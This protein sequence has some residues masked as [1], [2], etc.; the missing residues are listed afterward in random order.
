MIFSYKCNGTKCEL[1]CVASSTYN[2]FFNLSMIWHQ[3]YIPKVF[4]FQGW[5]IEFYDYNTFYISTHPDGHLVCYHFFP[6]FNSS[7]GTFMYKYMCKYLFLTFF[8]FFWLHL[9]VCGI[10]NFSSPTRDWTCAPYRELQ[11][12]NHWTTKED[13]LIFFIRL[14]TVLPLSFSSLSMASRSSLRMFKMVDLKSL[15]R[16]C[17]FCSSLQTPSLMQ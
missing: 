5:I 2:G 12:L 3:Y 7:A 13:P 15:L 10:L 8:F 6:N 14:N 16:T 9:V 1:F 17:K 4:L 11:S